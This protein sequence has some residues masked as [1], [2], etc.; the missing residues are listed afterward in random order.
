MKPP[1]SADIVL[2]V[3][4][5]WTAYVVAISIGNSGLLG[6]G[7]ALPVSVALVLAVAVLAVYRYRRPYIA[8]G[9]VAAMAFPF[10]L[11]GACSLLAGSL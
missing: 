5:G 8:L 9:L 2:G 7:T 10:L 3:A 4:A 11:A 6:F 1:R